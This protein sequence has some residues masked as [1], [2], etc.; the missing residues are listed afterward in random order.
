[1]AGLLVEAVDELRRLVQDVVV[2]MH[3]GVAHLRRARGGPPPSTAHESS[4]RGSSK[5][6]RP[7]WRADRGVGAVSLPLGP[8]AAIRTPRRLGREAA[9]ATPSW[10]VE[11]LGFWDEVGARGG[12]GLRVS[13]RR[14]GG[15]FVSLLSP[16]PQSWREESVR[17]GGGGGFW[18]S[19]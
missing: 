7:Q 2:L 18:S 8:A 10:E 4:Q 11:G 3:E 5:R 14:R 13:G 6:A 19:K 9:A 17:G 12:T 15:G 1:M 16:F